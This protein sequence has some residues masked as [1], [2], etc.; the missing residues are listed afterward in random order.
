MF[1][2]NFGLPNTKD[3]YPYLPLVIVSSDEMSN[4][5]QQQS[6]EATTPTLPGPVA[7]QPPQASTGAADIFVN[8]IKRHMVG[9]ATQAPSHS[10]LSQKRVAGSPPFIQQ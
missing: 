4:T 8:G 10:F 6:M 3:L 5:L 2:Y 1:K 9:K 7:R